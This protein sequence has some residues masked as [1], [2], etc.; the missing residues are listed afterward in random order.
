MLETIREFALERLAASGEADTVSR[1]HADYFA[2]LAERTEREYF[3]PEQVAWVRRCLDELG[4]LGPRSSGAPAAMATRSWGCGS[5]R[6][7][8][9]SGG[10]AAAAF[11]A[12][13]QG[14]T[15]CGRP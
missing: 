14:E 15:A 13:Q 5:P 8:G 7:C 4:N 9:G 10:Y 1:R 6:R 2:A 3:G 12:G 11:P